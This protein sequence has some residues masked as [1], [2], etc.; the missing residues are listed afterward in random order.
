MGIVSQRFSPVPAR[1]IF[2]MLQDIISATAAPPLTGL[3]EELE[4]CT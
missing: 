4:G 1:L 3:L 2:F